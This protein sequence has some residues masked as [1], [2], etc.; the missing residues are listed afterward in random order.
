MLR[1]FRRLNRLYATFMGFSWTK[2]PK[3]GQ[4]FGGHEIGTTW[5]E[6]GCHL[7]FPY[8]P[9]RKICCWKHG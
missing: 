7:E 4:W 9:I 6:M 1:R 2:C 5:V 3:C 8:L